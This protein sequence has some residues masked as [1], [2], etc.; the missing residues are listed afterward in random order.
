MPILKETLAVVERDD[1]MAVGVKKTR[2]QIA[3]IFKIC[4][5]I[6]VRGF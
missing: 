4:L 6:V 1:N 3:E 5:M 2:C